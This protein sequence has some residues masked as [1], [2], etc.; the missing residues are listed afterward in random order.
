MFNHFF[1][2]PDGLSVCQ[3]FL[4][5]TPNTVAIVVDPPFGGRAEFLAETLKRY[6]AMADKGNRGS[7]SNY[8]GCLLYCY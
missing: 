4:A 6:W 3:K 5:E 7:D 2:S 8:G 1:Y